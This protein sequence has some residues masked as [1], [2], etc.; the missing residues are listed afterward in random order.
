MEKIKAW[1]TFSKSAEE[2]NDL[3]YMSQ[4][5]NSQLKSTP[6]L[7]PFITFLD[8]MLRLDDCKCCLC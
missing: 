3:I 6:K 5:N 1:I 7:G 2:S 8:K 4:F